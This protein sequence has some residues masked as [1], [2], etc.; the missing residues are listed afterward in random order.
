MNRQWRS[1]IQFFD[2]A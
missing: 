1:R 2:S